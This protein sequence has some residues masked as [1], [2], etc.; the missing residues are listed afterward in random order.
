MTTPTLHSDDLR[1]HLNSSLHNFP[2]TKRRRS[3]DAAENKGLPR[4][5][6][7]TCKPHLERTSRMCAWSQL[8]NPCRTLTYDGVGVGGINPCLPHSHHVPLCS[9]PVR[10]HSAPWH[11]TTV[12]FVTSFKAWD[13]HNVFDATL[14]TPRIA[15]CTAKLSC[16]AVQVPYSQ[17]RPTRSAGQRVVRVRGIWDS[18]LPRQLESGVRK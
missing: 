8:R 9:R 13:L 5:S 11:T 4:R 1:L 15:T 10:S 3:D 16:S 18:A 12:L 2:S 7:T 17:V 14:I 6:T